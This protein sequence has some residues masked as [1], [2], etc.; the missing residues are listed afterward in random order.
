[1][2]TNSEL[3]DLLG[4]CSTDDALTPAVATGRDASSIAAR[5]K[6]TSPSAASDAASTGS[7]DDDEGDP[8]HIH[9][10]A[11]KQARRRS[12]KRTGDLGADIRDAFCF[13]SPL[14]KRKR[15]KQSPIPTTGTG[16]RRARD[17][18]RSIPTSYFTGFGSRGG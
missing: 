5:L 14:R 1:M 2:G 7:D 17:P 11:S 13:A 9:A 10:H 6:P 4:A 15:H 16:R 12:G 3:G 18:I 8:Q